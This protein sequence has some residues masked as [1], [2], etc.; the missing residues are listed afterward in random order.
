M[1]GR[2]RS[3]PTP[4]NITASRLAASPE[5]D[6]IPGGAAPVSECAQ[7]L[8]QFPKDASP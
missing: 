4:G 5:F 7:A 1:F 8:L 6:C 2:S 3:A